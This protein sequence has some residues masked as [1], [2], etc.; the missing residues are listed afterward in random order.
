MTIGN[1]DMLGGE[2]SDHTEA[3]GQN[4]RITTIAHMIPQPTQVM[5]G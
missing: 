2:G 3:L 1:I 4:S 5:V